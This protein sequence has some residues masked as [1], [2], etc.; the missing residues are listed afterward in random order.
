MT[1]PTKLPAPPLDEPP[2]DAFETA[3]LARLR[4]E[5]AAQGA[6]TTRPPVGDAAPT[7]TGRLDS[8]AEP[9]PLWRRPAARIAAAAAVAAVAAGS[10]LVSPLG[11]APAFAVE[12]GSEGDVTVTVNRLEGAQALEDALA[13]AGIAADVTY[14]EQG[15]M[16]RSG[17]YTEAPIGWDRGILGASA[18]AQGSQQLSIPKDL[19]AAGQTL[20]LESMW[21]QDGAWFVSVGVAAG[22]VAPCQEVPFALPAGVPNLGEPPAGGI[23]E[24]AT[25]HADP[26]A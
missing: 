14:P 17:R 11:T 4:E 2:L 15:T 22:P 18:T 26:P 21:P 25:T 23:P 10:Y 12:T 1:H 6:A 13:A 7:G 19:L 9:R 16:C 24:V 20:V 3:L 5:V 8:A